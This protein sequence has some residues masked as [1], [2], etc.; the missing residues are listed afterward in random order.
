[1]QFLLLNQ[2]PLQFTCG[3]NDMIYNNNKNNNMANLAS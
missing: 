2:R 3:P 1:M